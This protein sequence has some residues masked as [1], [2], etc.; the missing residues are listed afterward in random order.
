M[1]CFT[2]YDDNTYIRIVTIE[3]V[4]YRLI[5]DESTWLSNNVSNHATYWIRRM[6][7]GK[8]CNFKYGNVETTDN[9]EHKCEYCNKTF[10]TRYGMR[11]HIKKCAMAVT[12][13]VISSPAIDDTNPRV[14]NNTN[15][16]QQNIVIRPFGKENPKWLTENVI[17]DALKNIPHAITNLIRE[18]H[19]NDSFPENRNIQTCNEYKNRFL[20]VKNDT[21]D[22]ICDRRM[23]IE[24]LCN[25]ACD[26]VTT[27]LESYAE[28]PDTD[29]DDN[30]TEEDRQCH[31]IASKIRSNVCFARLVDQYI[32]R[33]EEFIRDSSMDEV[34]DKVNDYVT[35]L[36]LDLKLAL[37]HEERT[38]NLRNVPM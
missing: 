24:T 8:P 31:A 28:P 37:E 22:I 9:I 12:K 14:I 16:I 34:A 3:G 23:M 19:F 15:N 21:R 2:K 18:K 10:K 26:V 6:R 11:R 25:N 27:T 13:S 33:W 7:I 29:D 32:Q 17:I 38:M 4:H 5:V 30:E 35:M 20:T 1:A 36:L